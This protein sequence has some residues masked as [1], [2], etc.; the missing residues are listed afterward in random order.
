[1]ASA[2]VIMRE[3][4]RSAIVPSLD[5]IYGAI[6]LP[7][8][9]G[10][11]E[12]FLVTSEDEY[13]NTFGIPNPKMGVAHYSALAY[14]GQSNK[15]WVKRV[16]SADARYSAA[17]IRTKIE[18]LPLGIPSKTWKADQ[19]V[20]PYINGLTQE[21]LDSFNFPMYLG[22]RVYAKALP[23][24]KDAVNASYSVR[25]TSLEGFEVGDKLTFLNTMPNQ[26]STYFEIEA[27]ADVPNSFD[28]LTLDGIVTVTEG[29]SVRQVHTE[30]VSFASPVM[31]ALD[32][33]AGGTY[34]SVDVSAL[35]QFAVNQTLVLGTEKTIV[36]SI[37][38]VLNQ[39]NLKSPLA[40]AYTSGTEVKLE[41]RE[42]RDYPGFPTLTRSFSGSN[43]V[44]ISNSDDIGNGDLIAIGAGITTSG[45]EVTVTSKD[46]YVEA[47]H[48]L[49]LDKKA[50]IA[51]GT[52]IYK[53]TQYE[54]EYRDA[55]LAYGKNLG[56]WTKDIS[57]G[58]VPSTNYTLADVTEDFSL[59]FTVVV[60][61]K[62]ALVETWLDV[63]LT[64]Q[65]DGNGKQ[66]FI[67]SRV[68]QSSNYVGFKVN[69][70]HIDT[71]GL[72][73]PP[74]YS[75]YSLWRKNPTDIFW[76]VL[77]SD[78]STV[79]IT[80]DLIAQDVNI[81]VT[82]F[83]NVA[84]GDRVKFKGYNQEY[85]I[86][87]KSSFLF[88]GTT[89]YEVTLDR[90][91][92]IDSDNAI[93]KIPAG[94]VLT[95]FDAS[96][97]Q[98][99]NGIYEGVQYYPVTKLEAVYYN[100][101]IG[102]KFT[103]S[104]IIGTLF[105]AGANLLVGGSLGTAIDVGDLINGLQVFKST[106]EYQVQLFMDGGFAYPAYAQALAGIAES[107]GASFAYLSC[108]PSAEESSNYKSDIVAYR[109][110]LNLN[111][112][113]ASLFTGWVKIYDSYNKKEVWIAPDGFAAASQAFTT[114]N[115]AMWYPG[116]GWTRGKVVALDIKR[117]FSLGDRDFFDANQ[118]NP[119][120][121]KSGSGMVIWGNQTLLTKPSPL[122]MRSVRMLL[123]VIKYGLEPMLEWK[124]FELNT[125]RTWSIVEASI[126]A[127]MRDEIKAK[128]GVMEYQIEISKIITPSDIENERMPIFLGIKPTGSIKTIPVTIGIFSASQTI[129]VSA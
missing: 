14:L 89:Y 17:L 1:M 68:N 40:S 100:Y 121:Y 60:Y 81:R 86:I 26:S 115:F 117:K 9:K 36:A 15:L 34:L 105:D 114:R 19:I 76:D 30:V 112:S 95:K 24:I 110:S 8:T 13:L 116:S 128:D 111:T 31:L 99:S 97:S 87:N 41:Q 10:P 92:V 82:S 47:F 96:V 5:G 4:D 75:D 52:S 22:E 129:T 16:V 61:Y 90:G 78:G 50:T 107:R 101:P 106:E 72:S 124:H 71:E 119:I 122:Q 103:I 29:M 44:L 21:E 79:T 54:Y 120:R 74:L 65:I 45:F 33:A 62:G 77:G 49:T 84:L 43:E 104:G 69:R 98:T 23:T 53:I 55:L 42:Y 88:G 67:E 85:K 35:S 58:I 2:Q 123:I 57:I 28:K 108:D 38:L 102:A 66:M 126:N 20:A 32:S 39:V 118:V 93:N 109:N 64:E 12:P 11:T 70:A 125:E 51:D 91:I 113:Y 83:L 48:M 6:V 3:Q 27:L 80:E 7:A 63:S 25:V 127:F 56:A 46:T 18:D 37:D 59:P 73:I 94:V